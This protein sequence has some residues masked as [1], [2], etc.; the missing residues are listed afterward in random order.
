MNNMEY[1]IVIWLQIITMT[2][3]FATALVGIISLFVSGTTLWAHLAII[4]LVLYVI[5]AFKILGGLVG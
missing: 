2:I 3:I 1:D 4:G 5:S